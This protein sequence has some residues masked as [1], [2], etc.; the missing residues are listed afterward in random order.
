MRHDDEPGVAHAKV[1]LNLPVARLKGLGVERQDLDVDPRGLGQMVQGPGHGVML[2]GRAINGVSRAKPQAKQYAVERV[3]CRC[4][5]DHLAGGAAVEL[6]QVV[7]RGLRDAA[8]GD[9]QGV[10]APAD[11]PAGVAIERVREVVD[12]LRLGVRGRGVVE[13]CGFSHG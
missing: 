6:P 3:C 13:V 8:G 12:K 9:G 2:E 7:L 1:R 5:E 10:A 4:R 11:V